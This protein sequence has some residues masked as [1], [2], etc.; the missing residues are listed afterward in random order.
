[1]PAGAARSSPA[2]PETTDDPDADGLESLLAEMRNVRDHGAALGRKEREKRARQ[3]AQ[4]F[5]QALN[6]NDTALG[7]EIASNFFS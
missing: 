1:M 2:A 7:E 6:K 4:R 3:L 5:G